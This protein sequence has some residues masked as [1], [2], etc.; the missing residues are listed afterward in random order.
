MLQLGRCANFE[1]LEWSKGKESPSVGQSKMARWSWARSPEGLGVTLLFL[2]HLSIAVS[3]STVPHGV[4]GMFESGALTPEGLTDLPRK[5][6]HLLGFAAFLEQFVRVF[7]EPTF[8]ELANY[9]SR[10]RYILISLICAL[11]A[12]TLLWMNVSPLTV[13]ASA[14]FRGISHSS[15]QLCLLWLTE[16]SRGGSS[17]HEPGIDPLPIAVGAITWATGIG[18]GLVLIAMGL[19][20]MAS[21][22]LFFLAMIIAA[23]ACLLAVVFVT[24][25]DHSVAGSAKVHPMPTSQ[26]RQ[27]KL[28]STRDFF[29]TFRMLPML[30]VTILFFSFSL[31][32]PGGTWLYPLQ[33]QLGAQ[34]DRKTVPVVLALCAL[35]DRLAHLAYM[36]IAKRADEAENSIANSSLFLPAIIMSEAGLL[37]VVGSASTS[38]LAISALVLSEFP[39]TL[40]TIG[41]NALL[42]SKMRV[43]PF[44]GFAERYATILVLVGGAISS[45]VVMASFEIQ[46]RANLPAMV[47]WVEAGL[48]TICAVLVATM[49]GSGAALFGFDPLPSDLSFDDDVENSGKTTIPLGCVEPSFDHFRPTSPSLSTVTEEGEDSFRQHQQ[50]QRRRNSVLSAY[51]ESSLD[52]SMGRPFGDTIVEYDLPEVAPLDLEIHGVSPIPDFRRP[53]VKRSSSGLGGTPHLVGS[54]SPATNDELSLSSSTSRDLRRLRKWKSS[55]SGTPSSSLRGRRNSNPNI[56]GGD[57]SLLWSPASE[58]G[59][60]PVFRTRGTPDTSPETV[61]GGGGGSD[62]GEKTPPSTSSRSVSS[63]HRRWASV[64]DS[65]FLQRKDSAS[66]VGG[67]GRRRSLLRLELEQLMLSVSGSSLLNESVAEEDEGE[68]GEIV[69][70]KPRPV[71]SSTSSA[72]AAVSSSTAVGPEVTKISPI[73]RY[74]GDSE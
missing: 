4:L 50:Q 12:Q 44:P 41:L 28:I 51:S 24:G 70:P 9:S 13:I 46:V 19:F 16:D 11:A 32:L 71:P 18:A 36:V 10:S 7:A 62:G 58:V 45:L 33:H 59:R 8:V 54:L 47:F 3:L 73:S 72:A 64:D 53:M 60:S 49:C 55:E 35:L 1:G 15:F 31:Q 30:S 21:Q 22:D 14:V 66:S 61:T 52:F 65:S 40:T 26:A 23:S 48:L 2:Q 17:S 74:K 6:M 25:M 57:G 67:P 27:S 38:V 56:S 43:V 5:A 69:T 34:L 39:G 63:S 42:S 37:F 68:G 20:S 29:A